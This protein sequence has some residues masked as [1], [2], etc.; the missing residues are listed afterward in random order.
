MKLNEYFAQFG[1]RY[2]DATVT[3]SVLTDLERKKLLVMIPV[4]SLRI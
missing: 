4:A 1:W 2:E 3:D